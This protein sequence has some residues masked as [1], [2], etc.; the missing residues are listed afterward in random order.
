VALA[1]VAVV[2]GA[3]TPT[4][5]PPPG[6]SSPSAASA[7]PSTSPDAAAASAGASTPPSLAPAGLSGELTVWHPYPADPG[8]EL[9]AFNAALAGVQAAN[10]EL[11]VNVVGVPAAELVSRYQQNVATGSGP[12]LFVGSNRDLRTLADADATI[13]LDAILGEGLAGKTEVAVAGSTVDGQ[14]RMVPGSVTAAGLL[15]DGARVAMVPTTT[16][17]LLA[18]VEAEQIKLGLLSGSAGAEQLYGLWAAFGGRLFDEAGR[19]VA[20]QGGA[21][22][23]LAYAGALKKAGARFF[24][25]TGDLRDA[26]LTGEVDMII[27]S[28]AGAQRFRTAIPGLAGAAL[29]TGPVGPARPMVG[30]DGWQVSPNSTTPDLAAAFALA[31]TDV[32]AGQGFVDGAGY[33]P[34]NVD[35]TMAD[36][37]AQA[38]AATVDL[39]YLR[40]Q[41]SA[42]SAFREEF[43]KALKRVLDSDDD[44]TE[45]VKDA[46]AAMNEAS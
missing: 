26:F 44:P 23:A 8:N 5:N 1:L 39:A 3:C 18:A 36:P 10:P 13:P 19:C 43:A 40:P 24:P 33:I 9:A 45:A 7:A 11:I 31:M 34:A 35:N 16:D 37:F 32:A 38:V 14:V 25:R 17:E 27:D 22:D 2:I 29:P 21:A 30:V 6:S 15:Y 46:C 20:D 42:A 41:G 4:P 12:D 28:P